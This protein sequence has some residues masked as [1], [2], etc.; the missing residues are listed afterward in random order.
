MKTINTTYYY[1]ETK[2]FLKAQAIS[3]IYA[4]IITTVYTSSFQLQGFHGINY[5][6]PTLLTPSLYNKITQTISLTNNL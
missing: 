5:F 6:K 1:D 4:Q 2:S 3:C